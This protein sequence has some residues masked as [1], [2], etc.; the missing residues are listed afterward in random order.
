M[1]NYTN[2]QRDELLRAARETLERTA[3][4]VARPIE[5]AGDRWRRKNEEH[6]REVEHERKKSEV[7]AIENR[8]AEELRASLTASFQSLID[9]EHQYLIDQLLP[10]LIAA[11]R[12]AIA[13]D[14]SAAIERAYR[15][16]FVD[17]RSD[18]AALRNAMHKALGPIDVPAIPLRGPKPN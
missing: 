12:D 3:S 9:A 1:S 15:V 16:A 18:V 8:I 13:D 11:E 10:E 4:I 2:E 6:E 5:D 17:L 14:I 7:K